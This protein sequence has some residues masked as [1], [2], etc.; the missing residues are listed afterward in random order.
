MTEPKK[1]SFTDAI[2]A[3]QAA[4]TKVPQA[5]SSKVQA[6]K[7]KNQSLINR[8]VKRTGARGG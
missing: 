1:T 6:A 3:A 4:K 7:F 5:T 2:K 8:P